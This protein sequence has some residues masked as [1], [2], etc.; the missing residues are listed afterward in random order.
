[1]TDLKLFNR[2]LA[3][4]CIQVWAEPLNRQPALES[5]RL[6]RILLFIHQRDNSI[7]ALAVAFHKIEVPLP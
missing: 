3:G 7:A 4:A 6:Y 2:D 1:M 5:P